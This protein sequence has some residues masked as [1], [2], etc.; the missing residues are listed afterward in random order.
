MPGS[1]PTSVDEGPK[2]GEHWM[3][4]ILRSVL[5]YLR[6]VEELGSLYWEDFYGVAWMVDKIDGL[7]TRLDMLARIANVKWRYHRQPKA[8]RKGS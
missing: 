5:I 4:K 2:D 7:I 6:A 1:Y 3:I 8:R